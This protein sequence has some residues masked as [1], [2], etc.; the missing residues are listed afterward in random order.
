MDQQEADL[1]QLFPNL[2]IYLSAKED[3]KL[4]GSLSASFKEFGYG[5]LLKKRETFFDE[6]T[7]QEECWCGIMQG[8]LHSPETQVLLSEGTGRLHCDAEEKAVQR[9]FDKLL[10]SFYV[11]WN[12]PEYINKNQVPDC[13][14]NPDPNLKHIYRTVYLKKNSEG[15]E[16]PKPVTGPVDYV[17]NYNKLMSYIQYHIK[18]GT[19]ADLFVLNIVKD[20]RAAIRKVCQKKG[21][22]LTPLVGCSN[23]AVKLHYVTPTNALLRGLL[24]DGGQ[25]IKCRLVGPR[26][27]YAD[28]FEVMQK[29]AVIPKAIATGTLNEDSTADEGDIVI[30]PWIADNFILMDYFTEWNE[31]VN[32]REILFCS[33]RDNPDTEEFIIEKKRNHVGLI[34][35]EAM[36]DRNVVG[37]SR[38]FGQKSG[39]MKAVENAIVN[40]SKCCY[41]IKAK[42]SYFGTTRETPDF[43]LNPNAKRQTNLYRIAGKQFGTPLHIIKNFKKSCHEDLY[44]SDEYS[45]EERKQIS[46]MA[47]QMG[48]FIRWIGTSHILCVYKKR[49]PK[50]ILE[51]LL[52]N[53]KINEKYKLI[54]PPS[55][56][57][58]GIKTTN[59]GKPIEEMPQRPQEMPQSSQEFPQRPQEMHQSSH[60]FSQ[61]PQEVPQTSQEFS[62]GPQEMSQRPHA[63][64]QRQGQGMPQRPQ[65]MPPAFS[66]RPRGMPQ[67]PHA[68]SQRPRGMPER[69]HAFSQRPQGMP[70]R[71]HAFSQRPRG[72][73]QR[74]HAFPQRPQGMPQRPHEFSQM[75]QGMS[76]SQFYNPQANSGQ[77]SLFPAKTETKVS[78][79][80]TPGSDVESVSLGSDNEPSWVM[81]FI[82]SAPPDPPKKPQNK[83]CVISTNPQRKRDDVYNRFH[84]FAPKPKVVYTPKSNLQEIQPQPNEPLKTH[85]D[86]DEDPDQKLSLSERLSKVLQGGQQNV[87]TSNTTIKR[88][89]DQG[90]S[91]EE[92]GEPAAKYNKPSLDNRGFSFSGDQRRL[93]ENPRDF[94]SN[95]SCGRMNSSMNRE[96]PNSFSDDQRRYSGDFQHSNSNETMNLSIK[97]ETS[98]SVSEGQRTLSRETPGTSNVNFKSE[99]RS[100]TD[101]YNRSFEDS[102]VKDEYDQHS[103]YS[104]FDAHD[105]SQY[106]NPYDGPRVKPE[107]D[108]GDLFYRRPDSRDRDS[109]VHNTAQHNADEAR[110]ANI[111]KDSDNLFYRRPQL[112]D[113]V[114]Q[115]QLWDNNTKQQFDQRPKP[116]TG[117]KDL[118]SLF[119]IPEDRRS[120]EFRPVSPPKFNRYRMNR[121]SKGHNFTKL[122]KY[123]NNR[124]RPY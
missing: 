82:E 54:R 5:L 17:E 116:S 57:C 40:L 72:M 111:E 124:G 29:V 23:K 123:R 62:Q 50:D 64:S 98:N 4:F 63:F 95:S 118:T 44:F 76:Q 1:K 14:L 8:G 16:F 100:S 49:K 24:N 25:N 38:G 113:N 52:I 77:N 85:I 59:M 46:D 96:T 91:D 109:G 20:D 75:P 26:D 81:K 15:T 101:D 6:V 84:F 37:R 41:S 28:N 68:F 73:P 48:L 47:K 51:E 30:S 74:P 121:R 67:R 87:T 45:G 58:N 43:L 33:V 69:P 104:R 99:G 55:K 119:D 110:A 112:N 114:N 115:N 18:N 35:F 71:P 11:I 102:Y 22:T 42:K 70:Q 31:L 105:T 108:G 106:R 88:E 34:F 80:Q 10:D 21:M 90:I 19:K 117:P 61:R 78:N 3:K 92:G 93:T 103:S 56:S 65:G 86:D 66:Q 122:A 36:I 53:A 97:S 2:V 13:A 27:K 120:Q 107:V 12:N 39:K 83:N 9:L 79:Q 32:K 94:Q 89:H 7:G 60:E